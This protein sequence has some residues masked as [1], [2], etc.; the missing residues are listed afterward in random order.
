MKLAEKLTESQFNEMA[1]AFAKAAALVKTTVGVGNNAAWMACLDAFDHIRQHPA[2]RHRVKAA[3]K[4]CFEAL[5]AY[6]RQLVH[7]RTNRFFHLDDMT[8]ATRKIYGNI[9]DRDYYDFWAA[10][11]Y[12]AYECNK[13]FYTCLV[14]KL[15]LAY[16]AHG[17]P[18]P[19]ILAWSTAAGLCL[20]MAA[21][22]YESA[23]R[24]CTEAEE[25]QHLG[26][27]RKGWEFIFSSF[28]ISHVARLWTDA[29][30][31]LSGKREFELEPA[32]KHNVEIGYQQ[33]MDKW[34]DAD[35]LFGSRIKTCEDYSEVFR[36]NGEMK[37]T[38]REFANIRNTIKQY[39][40]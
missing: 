30:R 14:N 34:L 21:Q 35:S 26:I 39:Q 5:H 33:L 37:K 7:A 19:D 16:L 40:Q 10:F 2:Y 25:W 3:Y 23:I 24:R 27:P 4:K 20:D 6:E 11:G 17:E 1:Q 38:Q 31:L 15:R 22:I 29:H 9:T 13:P 8:P 36:T 32:E 28:N 12:T 18:Y